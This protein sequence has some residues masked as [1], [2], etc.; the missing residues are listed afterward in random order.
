MYPNTI[1]AA[2]VLFLVSIIAAFISMSIDIYFAPPVLSKQTMAVFSLIAM[3]IFLLNVYYIYKGRNWA[4]I[5]WLVLLV[6]G[7]AVALLNGAP[8]PPHHISI[9]YCYFESFQIVLQTVITILLFLP[10]S[11]AWFA[12]HASKTPGEEHVV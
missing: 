7:I 5:L 6:A 3:S 4:R 9:Y 10:D 2:F 11:N 8:P 12:Q 1:K